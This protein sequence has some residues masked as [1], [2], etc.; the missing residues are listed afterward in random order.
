MGESEGNGIISEFLDCDSAI[1]T[2]PD[3]SRGK[4][5]ALGDEVVSPNQM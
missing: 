4:N 1:L 2:M 3:C 5:D